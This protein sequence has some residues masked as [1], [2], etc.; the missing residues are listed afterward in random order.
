MPAHDLD[1]FNMSAVML[2]VEFPDTP[3]LEILID[4]NVSLDTT[5]CNG[6]TALHHA[7]SHENWAACS[8]LITC[9]AKVNAQ[10]RTGRTPL[11][12][13]GNC[14]NLDGFKLLLKSGADPLVRDVCGYNVL[15]YFRHSS[16]PAW[17]LLERW[18]T[19]HLPLSKHERI[20]SLQKCTRNLLQNIPS[21]IPVDLVGREL[22]KQDLDNLGVCFLGLENYEDARVCFEQLVERSSSSEPM[23]RYICD[24]CKKS[25][26]IGSY[27]FCKSCIFRGICSDC[28]RVR[29]SGT[30]MFNC[31]ADHEYLK[32]PGKDWKIVGKD[33]VNAE[34]MTLGD[35]I[36]NQ[37][38]AHGVV[39]DDPSK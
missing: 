10:T 36:A 12:M 37:K 5:D 19:Q 2:A 34:H 15:D 17:N 4:A 21:A 32:I 9:G 7:V 18:T 1:Y 11:M 35:W 22:L 13:A 29:S 24:E 8:V 31:D 27:W 16:H 28:F 26:V 14:A 23:P 33:E 39:S 25:G 38:Q 6:W 20:L 30:A 3:L